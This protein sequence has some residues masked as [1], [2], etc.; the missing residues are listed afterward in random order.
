MG[1]DASREHAV[2]LRSEYETA[3]LDAADLAP[4]P[5]TQWWRWYDQAL[6]AG[7][8]EPNAMTLATVDGDGRPD[9]RLVL[10]RDV[11]VDGFAF[12]T[13]LGSAKGAQ[14]AGN[15][16][17]ALVFAWLEL[18]RQVRV[19]GPVVPVAAQAADAYF[20]ERPRG[21][22]VGAWASPQSRPLADRADLEARVAAATA[23]FEGASVPRPPDWGGWRVVPHTVEF[24]Q[25]RPSRLHDRLVYTRH[26][27]DAPAADALWTITRLAP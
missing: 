13:N 24:W 5:I 12:Y 7:C 17:A 8:V 6:A 20:A 9:A 1:G 2:R 25:G 22:Q 10:V 3:G 15:P 4:D 19:R 23:R 18:H 11:S 14:L 21:S 26:R 27:G 16:S